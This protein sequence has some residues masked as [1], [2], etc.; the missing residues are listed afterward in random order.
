M[1][2]EFDVI[3]EGGEA[4]GYKVSVYS[5]PGWALKYDMIVHNECFG[6][7]ADDDFVR[8]ITQAHFEGVPAVFAHCSL[9][10]YRTAPVAA[11]AWRELIG[12]TSGRHEKHRAVLTQN[13][14]VTP[15]PPGP[16]PGVWLSVQFRSRIRD[17]AT[18]MPGVLAG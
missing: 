18:G 14:N 3:H 2:I 17:R 4:R 5:Q 7:V 16:F 10:S 1:S 15:R 13:V 8:S 6:G 12:V 9:R 11:D